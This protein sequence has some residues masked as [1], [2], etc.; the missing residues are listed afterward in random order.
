MLQV[1]RHP[2]QVAELT[3]ADRAGSDLHRYLISFKDAQFDRLV[4]AA[5][6]DE[7]TSEDF[8]AVQNSVSACYVQHACHCSATQSPKC[9]AS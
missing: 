6:R 5:A 1:P 8:V 2:Q 3:A 4:D 9:G 7:F